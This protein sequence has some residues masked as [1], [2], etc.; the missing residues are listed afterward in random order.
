TGIDAAFELAQR[1]TEPP[2]QAPEIEESAEPGTTAGALIQPGADEAGARN[3][4]RTEEGAVGQRQRLVGRAMPEQA[5]GIG[6]RSAELQ[7]E[8]DPA[9][10]AAL[11]AQAQPDQGGAFES[12]D[13]AGG[14]RGQG[15]RNR[16]GGK[17]QCKDSER[18][19]TDAQA[20]KQHPGEN[21]IDHAEAKRGHRQ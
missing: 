15:E 19:R 20:S 13:A 5:N 16:Q 12:E 6:D 1:A 7:Q 4:Q 9:R 17:S 11:L 21:R 14:P 18:F 2:G 8:A 3:E 10:Q